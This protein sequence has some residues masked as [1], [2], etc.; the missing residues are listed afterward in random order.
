MYVKFILFLSYLIYVQKNLA[1]FFFKNIG[2]K[3]NLFLIF[4]SSLR[5][6]NFLNYS[7][8]ERFVTSCGDI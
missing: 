4:L 6:R 5:L 3:H 8:T 2:N 7:F 1:V